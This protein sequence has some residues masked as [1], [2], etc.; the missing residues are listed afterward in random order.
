MTTRLSIV[1]GT[2]AD[3]GLFSP[4]LRELKRRR[5][6]EVQ[7]V[8]TGMHLSSEFGLTYREIEENGFHIDEKVEML[9][10]SDSETAI[11]KSIGLG[12]IGFGDVF[13]RLKPGAVILLGDRFET[14]A[15]AVSA[16]MAKIPIAH[17]HGGEVTRGAFDDALRHSITKMAFLHF[18]STETYRKRVI[19]LGES[20]DRVFNVG[21]LGLDNIRHS[22]LLSRRTLEKDLGIG[23]HPRNLLVTFHPAT[24]DPGTWG[25]QFQNLLAV[26][27]GLAGTQIIFTKANADT[28]GRLINGMIDAFVQ[29]NPSASKA[30]DSLGYLRYLSLMQFVDGVV[31]NSSSGIIEA[32]SFRIGTVNIGSRQE[33]RIRAESV[34][35]CE[36]TI[37][38]ITGALEKLYDPQFR[39]A[40]GHVINPHG[41][42][43][44]AKRI[45]D[46]LS[47]WPF[48]NLEPKAFYD[49][50][51]EP[52][53]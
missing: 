41:D 15:A 49:I 20:P 33:G 25:E 23:R 19:Q 48:D 22:K 28:G 29:K 16:F 47:R 14:F 26:L 40:L 45:C 39:K 7:I 13:R 2:R 3:F 1:T 11:G 38:G 9:L 50:N 8:A 42:G 51:F 30:F 21:A 27:G 52:G 32:P 4:L 34:I 43:H 12:I 44:S 5:S 31:G 17:I 35:D 24:L 10:S 18:T 53:D 46:I 36:P 6:F 37:A